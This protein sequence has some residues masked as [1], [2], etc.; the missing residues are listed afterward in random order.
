MSEQNKSI[1]RLNLAFIAG[2]ICNSFLVISKELSLPIKLMLKNTFGHQW[3]GHGLITLGVFLFFYMLYPF[4][5]KINIKHSWTFI[6][7][8]ISIFT[9][10]IFYLL[11]IIA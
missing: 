10:L 2:L 6:I 11:N 4:S 1:S 8:I 5:N 3:I 7:L 9:I